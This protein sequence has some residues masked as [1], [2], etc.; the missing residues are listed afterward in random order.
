MFNIIIIKFQTIL[1]AS[2]IYRC[3]RL[4]AIFESNEDKQQKLQNYEEENIRDL[5][6]LAN[7][8]RTDLPALSRACLCA[9]ITLDV[10][11]RDTITQ[12]VENK[13]TNRYLLFIY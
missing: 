13:I 3:Q 2:Q 12:L 10:H 11:A 1:A 5:N 4:E 9:L 8:V 6:D 7:L